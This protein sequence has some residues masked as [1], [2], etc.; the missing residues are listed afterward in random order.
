M[1]ENKYIDY[2]SEDIDSDDADLY[3]NI[4]CDISSEEDES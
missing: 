1:D 3:L 2:N 4:N